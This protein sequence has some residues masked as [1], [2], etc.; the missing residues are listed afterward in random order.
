LSLEQKAKTYPE[1]YNHATLRLKKWVSLEDVQELEAENAL[2]N[3]HNID[4]EK[5][6]VVLAKKI[7]EAKKDLGKWKHFW[8]EEAVK[9]EKA[10]EILEKWCKDC[11][12]DNLSVCENDCGIHDLRVI[13]SPK[14]ETEGTK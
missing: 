4:V 1:I 8:N 13:F 12:L 10:N 6:N 14:K 2:I 9:I 11:K 7:L 5:E 3:Q